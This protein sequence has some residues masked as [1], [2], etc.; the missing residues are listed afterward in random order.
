[1]NN[2]WHK[3]P[4]LIQAIRLLHHEL[5]RGELTIVLL[6]LVLAVATV[7]SLAGFSGAIKQALIHNS[8]SFIAADRVLRSSRPIAP[9]VLTY[10]R[11]Q[12]L[13]TAQQTLMSSMVF[14]GEQMKLVSLKAVS[15]NYPLRGQLMIQFSPSSQAVSAN[16]PKLHHAWLEPN[17]MKTLKLHYGDAITL[18]NAQFTISGV[19]NSLPDAGFNVFTNQ[20]VI[21][22]NINDVPAT[23]LIQP[24]SRVTYKYLFAGDDVTLGAFHD[25]LKPQ[26]NEIQY[27]DDIKSRQSPLSN[28]LT[29]AEKYL[30]L[31]SMFGIILAAIAVAVASRRYGQRHVASVAVLKA[32]G[33]SMGYVRNVYVTQWALLSAISIIVGLLVGWLLLYLGLSAMSGYLGSTTPINLMNSVTLAIFTGLVCVI[34]FAC[35]PLTELVLTKSIWV[36]RGQQDRRKST[37]WLQLLLPIIGVVTLLYLFSHDLRFSALLLTSSLLV[38]VILMVAAR[39]FIVLGKH[40]GTHAGQAFQLAIANLKRR[41]NE[42][43]VQLISFTL[44]IQLLLLLVVIRTSLIS[45]WQ[46]QL[47]QYTANRFLVNISP[48][49]LPDVELFI[50][51]HQ[52]HTSELY[53]VVRGRLTAINHQQLRKPSAG[54]TTDNMATS[55]QSARAGRVGI[56]RELNMTWQSQLPQDNKIVQGK[57]WHAN[58]SAQVSVEQGVAQRLGIKLG[59]QLTFQVG[60]TSI[61]VPVTSIRHVNWQSMKPNFFMIFTPGVLQH[62][63]ATYLASM[64]I[65][66]TQEQQLQSFLVNHPT[67]IL[68]NVDALIHELRKVINQVSIAIQFILII[69]VLAGCLVLVAQVQATMEQRERELAILKTL[70]AKGALLRNSVLYEFV[71]QGI[72]A[73]VLASASMEII[74]Y[75]LQ[76]QVFN[77]SPSIH[78]RFWLLAIVSGAGAVG[79]MGFISC[80][81]LLRLSSMT[82][83][84]RTL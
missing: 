13:K 9:M 38:I 21:I 29:R 71:I 15:S 68:L 7:F 19:I 3:R 60:V 67:M 61:T 59:D 72:I 48:S 30:S 64:Y 12:H 24:G 42:N 2:I 11:Q 5:K 26:L 20:A 75:F 84:R 80:W 1:M 52:L 78:I 34:S 55:K 23:Q 47:P 54:E 81:R 31:A 35:T 40:I 66:A 79:A 74:V 10:A 53:P 76:T 41:A 39:F 56:G 6:S 46:A 57:F 65:S 16:M 37:Y 14:V 22:I 83:I 25:W 62:L 70:G 82:L 27:W 45:D 50:K 63:P 43:S 49:K 17:L 33:A 58:E 36:I 4:W 28:A 51:Q 44:A 77:M 69:V 32:M 18:G 73:G 8:N